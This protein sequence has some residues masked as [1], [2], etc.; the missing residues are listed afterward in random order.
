[1]YLS[2]SL[3]CL[4]AVYTV[5]ILFRGKVN[6]CLSVGYWDNFV[7]GLC[8]V[9]YAAFIYQICADCTC[10]SKYKKSLKY[11]FTFGL[12]EFPVSSKAF[13]PRLVYYYYY[14]YYYYYLC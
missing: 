13:S 14:Y 10:R 1:M 8:S 6:I 3:Q 12:G 11:Y 9:L 5:A 7:A 4:A 2:L